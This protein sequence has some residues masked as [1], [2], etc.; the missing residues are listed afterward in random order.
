MLL[1]QTTIRGQGFLCVAFAIGRAVNAKLTVLINVPPRKAMSGFGAWLFAAPLL[2]EVSC[3]VKLWGLG[4]TVSSTSGF[5]VLFKSWGWPPVFHQELAA[6]AGHPYRRTW[7]ALSAGEQKPAFRCSVLGDS[8]ESSF[9]TDE[10]CFSVDCIASSTGPISRRSFWPP[11]SKRK[12]LP[13]SLQHSACHC[14]LS[15]VR[16]AS[17]AAWLRHSV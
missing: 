15:F 5:K 7:P 16:A 11:A 14:A 8:M 10:D 6:T 9:P 4:L 2:N 12:R 3:P 17:G 13:H 1:L